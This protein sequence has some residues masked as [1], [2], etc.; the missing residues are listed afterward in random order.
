MEYLG[1]GAVVGAIV[2]LGVAIQ[3]LYFKADHDGKAIDGVERP[4][5]GPALGLIVTALVAFLGALVGLYRVMIPLLLLLGALSVLWLLV[6]RARWDVTTVGLLWLGVIA[7]LGVLYWPVADMTRGGLDA[8]VYV[9]T[10]ALLARHGSIVI[11]DS[12]LRGLPEDLYNEVF[13]K[14]HPDRYLLHHMRF[15]GFYIL[16][17]KDGLVLPQLFHFYPALL[18]LAVGLSG[19]PVGLKIN[20][21][22]GA[23]AVAMFFL[24]VRRLFGNIPAMI[25]AL[26]LAIST[27]EIWFSRYPTTEIT[28]QFL[29]FTMVWAIAAA[30]QT[31]SARTQMALG[32]VGGLALGE[33]LLLHPDFPFLLPI[34]AAYAI[35]L[36]L[37]RSWRPWHWAFFATVGAFGLLLAGYVALYA[38]PYVGD[39]YYHVIKYARSKLGL[40]I[41]ATAV[42]AVALVLVDLAMPRVILWLGARHGLVRWFGPAAGLLLTIV[43]IYAYMVR[44]G[45]L[46]TAFW[47]DFQSLSGYIGGPVTTGPATTFVRFGWYLSP[48]GVLLALGSLPRAFGRQPRWER[49]F[50]LAFLVEYA[51]IFLEETYAKTHYIY[52]MRRYVPIVFPSFVILVAV[53][54]ASLWEGASKLRGKLLR[55]ASAGL[56]AWM[57]FF[58]AYTDRT[59]IAHW[60]WGGFSERLG[61]LARH[62]PQNA[63]VLFSDGRDPPQTLATPLWSIYGIESYVLVR[64]QPDMALLE[65][66]LKQWQQQGRPVYALMGTNGGKLQ[67]SGFTLRPLAEFHLDVKEFE[68]LYDQKPLNVYTV[69]FNLGIYRLE[70]TQG[71]AETKSIQMGDLEFANLVGGFY[72]R[73]TKDGLTYRWTDGKAVL[74]LN[75]TRVPS[76]IALRASAGPPE[77]PGTVTLEVSLDGRSLGHVVID[78]GPFRWYR[79]EVPKDFGP[80]GLANPNLLSLSSPTF[81]MSSLGLSHDSRRLGVQIS[82]VRIEP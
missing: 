60:E 21:V 56:A 6:I 31:D 2:A 71:T 11:Q 79:V 69:P 12:G 81:K 72:E 33:M 32:T 20:A 15:A 62:I 46:A 40:I 5:L 68:Q 45:I 34:V 52:T 16:D 59:V 3:K 13:L 35:C 9:N 29:F 49:W 80:L 77:R 7:A 41:A 57:L 75:L 58:M 28:G 10:A 73:E 55:V 38:Y 19:T 27:V 44:P 17:G 78:N 1:L 23:L 14:L 67:P 65:G 76:A 36:R 22:V 54:I 64:D 37:L 42:G 53:A 74:S 47:G 39:L 82:E 50:W 18:G 26:L 48:P 43:G 4:L 25:S 8:G 24:A 51:L 30:H 61:E 66:Q 70:E 63:V